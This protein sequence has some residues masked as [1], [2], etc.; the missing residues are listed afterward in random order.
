RACPRT[1]DLIDGAAEPDYIK[2]AGLIL[3]ERNDA[4]RRVDKRYLL[5][6]IP[7]A[8]VA[9]A[10]IRIDIR[11]VGKSL[12]VAAINITARYRTIARAAAVI[13]H[14]RNI[15]RR[16]AK[17]RINTRALISFINAPAVI[18]AESYDI[19][20]FAC[21]LADVACPKL[22][23]AA[24]VERPAPRIAHADRIDLVKAVHTY[25]WIIRRDRIRLSCRRIR[26]I[27]RNAEKFAEIFVDV[28]CAVSRIVT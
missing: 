4:S 1:Q 11:T 3:A 10:V 23:R 27:R 24:A 9:R 16:R 28:L 2:F 22:M 18:S 20:F 15:I 21:A 6:R 25:I 26:D 19:D 13:E 7:H 12:S 17:A 14:G 8:D 5:V